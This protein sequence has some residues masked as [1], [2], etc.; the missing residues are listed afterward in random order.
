MTLIH[1]IKTAAIALCAT[2]ILASIEDTT[3][4]KMNDYSTVTDYFTQEE[5]KDLAKL[6]DFFNEQICV[7]FGKDKKNTLECY[8]HFIR[9]VYEMVPEGYFDFKIS[10]EEQQEIYKQI[11]DSLFLQIWGVATFVGRNSPD[12]LKLI[13]LRGDGKYM[14]FLN[15]LGK[16]YEMI[17]TYCENFRLAGGTSVSMVENIINIKEKYHYDLNDTRLQL[18]VAIHY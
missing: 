9:S 16:E 11:C 8:D 15:E 13:D 18:V 6:L 7:S 5:I 14:K 10:F 17:N 4:K 12:T 2:L 1:F 3:E